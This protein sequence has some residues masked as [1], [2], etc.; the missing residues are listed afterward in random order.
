MLIHEYQTIERSHILCGFLRTGSHTHFP[1]FRELCV[2]CSCDSLFLQGPEERSPGRRSQSERPQQ[3]SS[4]P[5]EQCSWGA[6]SKISCLELC[7]ARG[8]KE[9]STE[10]NCLSL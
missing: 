3:R 9:N 4:A 10:K 1:S 8:Q 2:Y 5:H 7:F 6:G